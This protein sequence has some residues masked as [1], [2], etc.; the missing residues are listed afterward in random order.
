MEAGRGGSEGL[1]LTKYESKLN[2]EKDRLDVVVSDEDHEMDGGR[3]D[4]VDDDEDCEKADGHLDAGDGDGDSVL[5]W[6]P[7]GRGLISGLLGLNVVLLGAALVA[8]DAFHPAGLQHQ[9]PEV[10]LLLLMGLS[11]V[12]MLWYL[13]WARKQP[14][15]PPHTD[16]H[17]GGPTVTVVLM[18]FAGFSLV[19][20][21]FMMVH[22]IL[23]KEC[24]PS[25]KVLL[26]FFQ[27]PFLG[28]QTYLLWA[29]SKDCIHKHRILTRS[30]L[31][32]ILCTDILLWLNAVTADSVHME[33]E[34]EREYKQP[35]MSPELDQDDDGNATDCNCGRQLVCPALRKGYEVLYPFNMEFSLLAGCM[36]YVMWK[37]VGRHTTGTH[38]G[39]SQKITLRILCFG[40]VLLGPVLGL[41]VLI[42]GVVIFVLYQVWVGQEGRRIRAFLLFYGFHLGVMPLMALCSLAGTV[43]FR[44]K[45]RLQGRGRGKKEEGRSAKNPTRRLDVLLLVGSGLGQLF[46]SYFSLVAA[47][48]L[49]PSDVLES[50]D[51]SYSL[52][53]LL[54]LVLQNMFIIQGLQELKHA[55]L[56]THSDQ[57]RAEKETSEGS[58][59]FKQVE[60]RAEGGGVVEEAEGQAFLQGSG[61][62]PAPP[63][64]TPGHDTHHW[65]RRVIQEICAF[66]ILSNVMLWVIPAFGAHPQFESGVGKQFYGFSVWFVLVNLGQPLIVFYR[67]HS[68]GA[69]MELLISA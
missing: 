68:V 28:L 53:S 24:L 6:V 2:P 25:A 49:G 21:V 7:T 8:G 41:L 40:G 14:G 1:E 65:R 30:G 51:L 48:A 39:H 50:L 34:M 47:L 18:L 20:C 33:I 17:A 19:L 10:F 37:N 56:H 31:M 67:M 62:A 58:V 69:L 54:E 12:W 52:L 45:E 16:H 9:E 36:L 26:P 35:I 64:G 46:L 23:M 43:V 38:S 3:L 44:C 55:S 11:V 42:S 4:V 59:G 60:R 57:K 32:V 5:L 27:T 61:D 29:H 22:N 66:L 15:L 63:T 13:L